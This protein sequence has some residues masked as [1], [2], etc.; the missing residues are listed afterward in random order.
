MDADLDR[1]FS[2]SMVPQ[3]DQTTSLSLLQVLEM[4]KWLDDVIMRWNLN[5][6]LIMDKP[7][8]WAR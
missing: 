6:P 4:F 2:C 1:S 7:R 3:R 8:R 5:V